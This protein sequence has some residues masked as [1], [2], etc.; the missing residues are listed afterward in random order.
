MT[1]RVLVAYGT[2]NGSTAQIAEA[3]AQV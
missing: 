2:T 1:G 3:V